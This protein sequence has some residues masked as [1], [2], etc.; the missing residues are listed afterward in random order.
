VAKKG[1]VVE[2]A[3]DEQPAMVAPPRV[4]VTAPATLVVAVIVA[5]LA[6]LDP[7]TIPAPPFKVMVGVVVAA[8]AE[9]TPN[10]MTLPSTIAPT[11][12]AD[13]NLFIVFPLFS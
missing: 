10:V 7:G 8:E 6:A 3:T 4:N 5:G 12:R 11:A 9:P 2:V 13:V 1:V